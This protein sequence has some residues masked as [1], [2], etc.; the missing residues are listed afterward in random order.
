MVSTLI[1]MRSVFAPI[2]AAQLEN[3]KIPVQADVGFGDAVTPEA[4]E[5]IF[6]TLLD[7]PAPKL[8]AYPIYTVVAEK[9]EAMIYLGEPNSRMKDF[10]DVWFLSQRFEFSGQTLMEAIKATF[11]QRKTP[12]PNESPIAFSKD[13]ASMKELQ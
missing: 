6:P 1:V 9:L 4:D 8:R 2:L 13:F 10:F 3:A 5:I 12:L 7:L 11:Q